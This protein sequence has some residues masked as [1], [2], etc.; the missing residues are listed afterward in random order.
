MKT[1]LHGVLVALVTPMKA[2]EEIDFKTLAKQVETLIAAGV[3]G[4]IPLGSTG[5]FYALTAEERRNVL[6]ATLEAASARV[7]VVA[8]TNA[9]STRD[10]IAF[11]REAEQLGCDGVMLAPPYYSLP[12]PEELHAHIK[13]VN[14]AIGIPIMLYNYP[15]RTGVDMTP[16]F[17]EQLAELPRVRYVKES[18]GEIGRISTLLRRCGDRLGI[19]CG[20]DTVAFESLA[21]GVVGWV[22]GVANVVPRSHVELYRLMIE[23]H[24]FAAARKL[25]FQMLPLLNL[26]EGGGKYTQ[27][28]KAACGLMGRPVGAPRAPLRAATP[29]ELRQLKAALAEIPE[30]QRV[31]KGKL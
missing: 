5:E 23:K 26:M 4:L 21:L 11:S 1:K 31:Q 27:W 29:P 10:V 7:P 17:I 22:G 30:G 25:Y 18:T 15:G 2:N 24:D 12:Q 9:G 19:F 16:E 14:D 20:G 6:K 3:H 8:G 28:V 13:A